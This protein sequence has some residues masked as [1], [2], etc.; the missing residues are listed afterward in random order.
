MVKNLFLWLI[1]AIVLVSVF[2]NFGPRNAN[3]DKVSY[4]Q[5]L[6]RIDQ[7][8]V[9]A[10]TVEDNRVIK[11]I[12]KNQFNVVGY[13]TNDWVPAKSHLKRF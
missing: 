3:T 5:F 8:M 7:G 12:T 2:S 11:G 4:S 9:M 13:I 10:V 1:I 6:K